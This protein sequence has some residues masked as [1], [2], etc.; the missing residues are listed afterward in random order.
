MKIVKDARGETRDFKLVFFPLLLYSLLPGISKALDVRE[1]YLLNLPVIAFFFI[2]FKKSPFFI[3]SIAFS[4]I[5]IS[6]AQVILFLVIADIRVD[7]ALTSFFLFLIPLLGIISFYEYE[8]KTIIKSIAFIGLI[9]SII[10]IVFYIVLYGSFPAPPSALE[11]V[12]KITDGTF[13]FRMA[14][15]SGSLGLGSLCVLSLPCIAYCYEVEKKILYL[16]ALF[17][18]LTAGFLTM[19][20]SAWLALLIAFTW[21]SLRRKPVIILYLSIALASL[22]IFSDNLINAELVSFFMDRLG[23]FTGDSIDP[24]SERRGMW[25]LALHYIKTSFI[26]IGVGQVGL[27]ASNTGINTEL[28]ITDGDYFRILSEMGFLGLFLIITLIK[29]ALS[30]YASKDMTSTFL[31]FSVL[32]ALVQMIGSN[33][34][35]FYFSNYILWTLAGIIIRRSYA[36]KKVKAAVFNA[37]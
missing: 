24:V 31:A 33:V 16:I 1:L 6:A 9:H 15:V 8:C 4:T 19:Q 28:L 10:G 18:I 21:F 22:L 14:S 3:R 20:R 12:R 17:A 26:G 13:I 2:G 29:T 5:L 34:T 7:A 36:Q 23:S 27:V 32:G 35:E 11:I 37:C 30:G 25:L